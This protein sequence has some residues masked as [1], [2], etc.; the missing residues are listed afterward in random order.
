MRRLNNCLENKKYFNIPIWFM[1]QAGRYLSE[2]REIRKNNPDFINLCLNPELVSKI[3]QQPMKRFDLDALIVFSDI[4]L[5]P[6]GLGQKVIFEKNFG[7]K[8]SDFNLDEILKCEETDCLAIFKGN[9]MLKYSLKNFTKMKITFYA[10]ENKE[11]TS[12]T[13]PIDG[14]TKALEDINRKLKS[15]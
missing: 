1:R 3:T 8:L 4:L 13:L 6:H 12:L 15:Q 9:R 10:P 2:F 11:P 14:F 5:I 7:P